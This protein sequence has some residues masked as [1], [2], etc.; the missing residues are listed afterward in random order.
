MSDNKDK[1]PFCGTYVAHSPFG[2]VWCDQ[3]DYR[4]ETAR[5]EKRP[6]ENELRKKLEA[7]LNAMRDLTS[8]L[9]VT[10]ENGRY[11]SYYAY[12]WIGYSYLVDAAVSTMEM[13]E[14]EDSQP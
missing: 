2:H 9:K 12:K 4:L 3:C 5:F 14:Q 11:G 1:C 10:E 13:L 8:N 7:A 6:I